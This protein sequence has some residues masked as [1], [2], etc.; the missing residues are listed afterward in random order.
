MGKGCSMKKV[1]MIIPVYNEEN[2]IN[3]TLD[4]AL[5]QDY[6]ELEV[7]VV[8][9]ASTDNTQEVLHDY[10]SKFEKSKI[11]YIIVNHPQNK[12]VSAAINSGLTVSTG[13]FLCFPDSDDVF[14]ANYVS[15]MVHTLESTGGNW[16][17]CDFVKIIENENREYQEILPT[18][19]VYKN[20]YYDFIS[21]LVPYNVWNMLV[22]SDYFYKCI[23]QEILDSPLT[24]E[25]SLMLPLSYYSDYVRCKEILYRYS[26][27]TGGLS[28]WIDGDTK[29]VLS[30]YDALH[31]LNTD[32]IAGLDKSDKSVKRALEVYYTYIKLKV[33]MSRGDNVEAESIQLFKIA[34]EY[35]DVEFANKIDSYDLTMR[36]A[37]DIILQMRVEQPLLQYSEIK[38]HTNRGFVI[39][40]D[41]Y[42]T[43]VCMAFGEPCAL[44]SYDTAYDSLPKLLLFENSNKA[45]EIKNKF[46]S[47]HD[48]LFYD[49][50]D[51]RTALRGW[52]YEKGYSL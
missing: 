10:I 11:N 33:K 18:K 41:L 43:A 17:R 16:V 47:S 23:G 12:G 35:L 39:Y 34:S 37:L 20:D 32:V 45:T 24:Q 14:V 36:F 28:R 52:A 15:S 8:N 5:E 27:R 25:W 51:I 21:K 7:V 46:T 30:H 1:S 31:S 26:V 29:S 48:G 6:E 4:C 49:L 44:D 40:G 22:R 19:S 38:K 3:A 13:D 2:Y 50:R 9:D 42:K